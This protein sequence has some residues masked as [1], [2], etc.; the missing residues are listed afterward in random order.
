M[1]KHVS[2]MFKSVQAT[3]GGFLWSRGLAAPGPPRYTP[4]QK[5]KVFF[6]WGCIR[7][8]F[9][10]SLNVFK[11]G[12]NVFKHNLNVFKHGWNVFKHGLNVIRNY[13]NAF[14]HD[15]HVRPSVRPVGLP[16]GP[17][18]SRGGRGVPVGLQWGPWRFLS[19]D[20]LKLWKTMF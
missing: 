7:N 17:W 4:T 9:K 11:H 20:F 13:L 2:T 19:K 3:H 12:W 1:F 5:S 18:G 15:W 10:Y 14:K 16:W 8:V 6:A